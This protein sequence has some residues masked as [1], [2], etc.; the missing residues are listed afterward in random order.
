M[1]LTIYGLPNGSAAVTGTTEKGSALT[2]IDMD[3]NWNAIATELASVAGSDHNPVTLGTAN[4][5][6]L[7]TQQLSLGVA[8]AGVTGA[9]SGGDWSTFNG[10]QN[11]L[12]FTAAH[13]DAVVHLAGTEVI[14][15][16]KTVQD[17]YFNISN[18]TTGLTKL[19]VGSGTTGFISSFAATSASTAKA[20]VFL[21]VG[22]SSSTTNGS[23]LTRNV[24]TNQVTFEV[25]SD[26]SAGSAIILAD[27]V[28]PANRYSLSIVSGVLT[29]TAL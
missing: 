24:S 28:T 1:T 19:N 16:A 8:S 7:S 26:M 21:G 25:L 11:A 12:G 6:S 23:V 2:W 27:T 4:G 9:L 29:V 15:G 22:S 13:D 18:S 10:K 5:L 17:Q 14:T 3:N 20:S